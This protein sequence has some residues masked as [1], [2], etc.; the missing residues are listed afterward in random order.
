MKTMSLLVIFLLFLMGNCSLAV[1][2]PLTHC[3]KVVIDGPFSLED[4]NI[5]DGNIIRRSTPL[6]LEQ[7]SWNIKGIDA[8]LRL[9][10]FETGHIVVLDL[11][12]YRCTLFTEPTT[13]PLLLEGNTLFSIVAPHDNGGW[14]RSG[15]VILQRN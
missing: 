7:S 11:K 10:M 14:F 9:K 3:D 13:F 1:A 6:I 2:N 8:R 15:K 5:K 4:I 12:R